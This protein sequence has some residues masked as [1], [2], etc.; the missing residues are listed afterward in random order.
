[1]PDEAVNP[2]DSRLLAAR[3]HM[4]RPGAVSARTGWLCRDDHAADCGARQRSLMDPDS[5]RNDPGSAQQG[6]ADSEAEPGGQHRWLGPA[7]HVPGPPHAQRH[8]AEPSAEQVAADALLK[9]VDAQSLAAAASG[10][11]MRQLAAP[12][13]GRRQ[14]WAVPGDEGG[15][16]GQS[17]Y[18]RWRRQ[19]RQPG[20]A[21]SYPCAGAAASAASSRSRLPLIRSRHTPSAA[22]PR[23]RPICTP[24][25]RARLAWRAI[26]LGK[27]LRP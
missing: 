5:K 1:M 21:S 11:R 10:H 22:P 20:S 24:L 25:C 12:A 7:V 23:P 16:P 6:A 26:H 15:M 4:L 18:R 27:D 9:V 14:P 19:L 2:R 3:V 8:D 13:G 17:E